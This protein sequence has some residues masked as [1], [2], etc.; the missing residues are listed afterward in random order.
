VLHK[1]LSLRL[2]L[3]SIVAALAGMLLPASAAFARDGRT[4]VPAQ[5][6]AASIADTPTSNRCTNAGHQNPCWAFTQRDSLGTPWCGSN[7]ESGSQVPFFPPTGKLA[8]CLASPDL[9]EIS[10]YYQGQP[11]GYGDS[12]EDHVIK[13]YSGGLSFVGHVPD[14]FVNL[15]NNNPPNVGIPLC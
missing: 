12:Y 11:V 2:V 3:V 1:P 14:F 8:A 4:M 5:S 6:T 9:V 15:N 13:E 10:C 7:P